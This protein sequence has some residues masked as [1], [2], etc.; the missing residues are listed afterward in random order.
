MRE[1]PDWIQ[2]PEWPWAGGKPMVFVGS[3][4]VVADLVTGRVR[5]KEHAADEYAAS[6][7]TYTVEK[8]SRKKKATQEKEA[9]EEKETQEKTTLALVTQE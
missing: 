4:G 2:D 7:H 1:R 9:P 3:I 8:A 6:I 5:K